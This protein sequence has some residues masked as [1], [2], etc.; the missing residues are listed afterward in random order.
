MLLLKESTPGLIGQEH[1]H[2]VADV[3]KDGVDSVQ[4]LIVDG[5][6][7]LTDHKHEVR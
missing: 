2:L 6:T 7:Q 1:V 4:Q 3:L 5:G